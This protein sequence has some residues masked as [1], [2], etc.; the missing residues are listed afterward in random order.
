LHLKY[1]TLNANNKI[2]IEN[3]RNKHLS[4]IILLKILTIDSIILFLTSII[5]MILFVREQRETKKLLALVMEKQGRI[6]VPTSSA[7]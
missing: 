2:R 7:A 4:K 6:Y 5:F 1:G 3:E